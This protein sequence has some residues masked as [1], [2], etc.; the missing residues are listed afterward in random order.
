[1]P[2]HASAPMRGECCPQARH[3]NGSELT[4]QEPVVELTASPPTI[5][6]VWLVGGGAETLRNG[7]VPGGRPSIASS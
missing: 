7:S 2:K 6:P 5:W 3:L 1:M 4:E